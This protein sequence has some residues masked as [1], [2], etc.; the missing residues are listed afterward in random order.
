MLSS[1]LDIGR[2]LKS[3]YCKKQEQHTCRSTTT[4]IEYIY[5][6]IFRNMIRRVFMCYIVRYEKNEKENE[7]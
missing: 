4:F 1:Y 3:A 6:H 7:N 5:T 2:L